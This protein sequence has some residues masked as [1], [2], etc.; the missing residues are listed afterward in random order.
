[1]AELERSIQ[2]TIDAIHA[3][4]ATGDDAEGTEI[5]SFK[6]KAI[7]FKRR[8]KARRV[9]LAILGV[10]AMLVVPILIFQ[11]AP[12]PPLPEDY[13]K[14]IDNSAVA[15][16]KKDYDAAIKIWND[17]YQG[18]HDKGS[19]V[20]NWSRDRLSAVINKQKTFHKEV[21]KKAADLEDL[22]K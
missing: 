16:E 6:D 13:K 22:A 9:A 4:N 14:A 20:A 19:D 2:D 17:F 11:L 18:L 10:T 3:A 8:Q 15:L 5:V 21:Y 12:K 1:K 7:K